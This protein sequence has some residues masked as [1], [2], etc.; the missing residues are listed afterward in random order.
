MNCLVWRLKDRFFFKDFAV[1]RLFFKCGFGQVE[2]KFESFQNKEK[3]KPVTLALN[4]DIP[5]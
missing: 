4:F 5:N 2:W 3:F 1:W